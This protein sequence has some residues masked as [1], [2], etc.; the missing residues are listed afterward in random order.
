MNAIDISVII[1]VYGVE[2]H[3]ERSLNSL[4]SQTKTDNVEFLIINDCTKD[5]SIVIAQEVIAN[6]SH[7]NVRVVHHSV[8]RGIAAARQTGIDEAV[9]E[10]I[11]HID[12][13]DWCEPKMLETMYQCLKDDNSDAV[14]ADFWIDYPEKRD[15]STQKCASTG[16]GC[17]NGLLRGELHGSL[18]N[19]L[20]R[21]KLFTD[22]NIRLVEGV[23]LW[24]DLLILCKLFCYAKG[25]SYLPKAYLHYI[26]NEDSICGTASPSKLKDVVYVIDDL[27]SFYAERGFADKFRRSL[28]YKKL[29]AK[30]FL[31]SF[32]KGKERAAFA[33]MYSNTNSLIMGMD[34]MT[35]DRRLALKAAVSGSLFMFDTIVNMRGSLRRLL[36]K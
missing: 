1:P 18:C 2:R 12:S 8:N 14:I 25:V 29:H 13:D 35:L 26:Q 11:I 19:K 17:V 10:Y 24:E 34:C 15:Y 16:E 3:I 33:K 9:G 22:N 30:Y 28:E 32:S 7:L 31:I 21:R 20:I 6:Y 27:D 4:F 23:N 36:K 5:N